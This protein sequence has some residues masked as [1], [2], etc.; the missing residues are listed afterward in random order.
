M[1][2]AYLAV[3]ADEA[4]SNIL[5][6]L[7]EEVRDSTRGCCGRSRS[8]RARCQPIMTPLRSMRI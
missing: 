6:N 7:H 8:R 5:E 4:R 1:T 2:G 3:S